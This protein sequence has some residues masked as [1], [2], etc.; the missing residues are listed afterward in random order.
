MLNFVLTNFVKNSQELEKKT[1]S[2]ISSLRRAGV[3]C[4]FML[5]LSIY[6]PS[7]QV[8]FINTIKLQYIYA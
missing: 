6:S 7:S 1:F 2:E 3:K 8:T 4:T 5:F